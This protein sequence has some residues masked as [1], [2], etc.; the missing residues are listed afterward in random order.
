MKSLPKYKTT[1][2]RE[3]STDRKSC[4][5]YRAQGEE[6]KIPL[7]RIF[8]NQKA[9]R[10]LNMIGKGGFGKVWKVEHLATGQLFAMK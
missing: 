4:E 3:A 7:D 5:K 2:K 9:Y 1:Q 10:Y 6:D 8:L